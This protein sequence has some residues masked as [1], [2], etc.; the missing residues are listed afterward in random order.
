MATLVFSALGTVL[1][2]PIGGAIGALIGR[3]VDTALIGSPSREGP[4]LK[5]LTAT[6]S[7][8]G[9]PLPRHFGQMRVGGSI[10]WATDLVEHRQTQGGGKGRPSVTSYSYS[11]SFAVALSSRPLSG[12]GRI[13][14]DGNL[15]RGAA[16]D[17]KTGGTLRFYSGQGDQDRD[18]LMAAAEA[19]LPCP[20]YRGLSY[21]VFE[22]LQLGDF[23]N[24]IPALT[25]EVFAE[26]VPFGVANLALDPREL[27]STL[28]L[29]GIDGLTQEGSLAETLGMLQPIMP[30]FYDVSDGKVRVSG[31]GG[32]DLLAL[33]D[34]TVSASDD[35]FGKR[36]GVA[37]KRA[38]PHDQPPAALRYYDIARDYQPGIQR[39]SGFVAPGPVA[40]VDVPVALDGAKARDFIEAASRRLDWSRQTVLWRSS[41][42]DPACRP[43]SLVTVPGMA[44]IWRVLSWEWRASGVELSLVRTPFA[45]PPSALSLGSD[46]GRAATAVDRTIGSTWL[47]AVELPWDGSGAGDVPIVQVT[48]SSGSAGWNGA[49]L[50]L[51]EGHGQ[52]IAAGW[53]GRT[54]AVAGTT[55]TALASASPLV[56]DRSGTVTIE[57]LGDDMALLDATPRQLAA[58]ANRAMIGSEILQFG[59][60][61]PLGGR[62]W[63]LELLMRGR[64][65]TELA[66]AGHSAGETFVLLDD[67]P[68]TLD[69]ALLAQFPTAT[70]KAIGPGDSAPATSSI[71]ARGLTQRPLF[72]VHPR[73]SR[74]ADGSLQ[75]N[76]TRRARAAWLWRD[77]VDAP[78]HEQSETYE[79]LL[80]SEAEIAAMWVTTEPS[81]T[82]AAAVVSSLAASHPGKPLIVR[83]RGTYASSAPL[84]ITTIS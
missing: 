6:T 83:Q 57:L 77:Q 37:V 66:I 28:P 5:E 72:P 56:I 43:G 2:G 30:L 25:F 22:D 46:T 11:A 18:P 47:A 59:R 64:G 35:E 41:E 14:A 36:S 40:T 49:A 3:Q 51:D 76:W 20:A 54:R 61:H 80:G 39:A 62:L 27:A 58:G 78:L 79:V 16:G 63:R 9:S 52:L 82:I 68:V 67:T 50:Y 81:L 24:R 32:L 42:I 4:R 45:A 33:R 74:L 29:S 71:R 15:L 19:S 8:Y 84:L 31:E 38:G 17:L 26:A 1:G 13:W 10:I 69:G 65:G 55:L 12:I 21:V 7:S 60:A 70:V 75:L 44:G 48:A 34:P 53:T 73:A 23:G